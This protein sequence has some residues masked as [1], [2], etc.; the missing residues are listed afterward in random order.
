MGHHF[1]WAG[2]PA[3][4]IAL[5]STFSMLEVIPLLVMLVRA[6]REY[7]AIR[8]AGGAFPQRTAFRFF[9]WA[10]IWNF[11]GAG[12]L[13]GIINPPIASYYEHGTFLT[14][15]HAHSSMFG[16][17]GLLALG[18]VYLG[19][20][21]MIPSEVW[22]DRAAT[23]V[24]RLF[25]AAIALWLALNL[26]PI[27]VGQVVAVIDRGY[28]YARSLD[29][30]EHWVVFEWLRLAGDVAFIAAGGLMLSDLV[31]KLRIARKAPKAS[32]PGYQ[33]EQ[34]SA[35]DSVRS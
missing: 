27:G 17:F 33:P 3:I 15:A 32:S 9:T 13:G 35:G 30:Y 4:W 1:Y 10:A 34:L 2:E 29:F 8:D 5:G 26:I 20:R 24:L 22:N 31:Q 23:W 14:L 28:W 18:L 7:R 12:I 16:V 25:N 21:A 11:L 19:V 6:G